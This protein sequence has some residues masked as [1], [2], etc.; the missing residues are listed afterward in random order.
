MTQSELAVA[1]LPSSPHQ[2]EIAERPV[3]SPTRSTDICAW[4]RKAK[5]QLA[6]DLARL[7]TER[8]AEHAPEIA[9]RQPDGLTSHKTNRVFERGGSDS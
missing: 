7:A 8:D 4:V 6:G 3:V 5:G 1:R 9:F 2:R